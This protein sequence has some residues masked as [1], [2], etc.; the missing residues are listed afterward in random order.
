MNIRTP[1]SIIYPFSRG[2]CQTRTLDRVWIYYW[3]VR[4]K[5]RFFLK[6]CPEWFSQAIVMNTV[7]AFKVGIIESKSVSNFLKIEQGM[8]D[9]YSTWKKDTNLPK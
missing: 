9:A 5:T 6:N 8:F 2:G 7:R 1:S 4:N 3:Y